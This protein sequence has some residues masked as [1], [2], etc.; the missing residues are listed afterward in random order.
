M[1]HPGHSG[2]WRRHCAD[3]GSWRGLAPIGSALAQPGD[4]NSVAKGGD[5]TPHGRC[6]EPEMSFEVR[7]E[8]VV[9]SVTVTRE[10][11]AERPWLERRD[12]DGVQIF[13]RSFSMMCPK[14]DNREGK[15]REPYPGEVVLDQPVAPERREP[16]LR[17]PTQVLEAN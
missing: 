2:M 3:V 10:E 6:R 12:A 5:E 7:L 11:L 14:T 17:A 9:G 16:E 15:R 13:A 4:A 1:P 8:R